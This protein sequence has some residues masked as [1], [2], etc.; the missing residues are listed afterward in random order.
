MRDRNY[1]RQR[2]LRRA[3]RTINGDGDE[4]C[5]KDRLRP[6]GRDREGEREDWQ[7][8]ARNLPGKESVA[9]RGTETCAR[10]RSHDRAWRHRCCRRMKLSIQKV[11][12]TFFVAAFATLKTP[13]LV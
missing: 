8:G 3:G 13:L 9:G 1:C 4:S 10:S 11:A 5:A 7:D 12:A 6:R 2:A